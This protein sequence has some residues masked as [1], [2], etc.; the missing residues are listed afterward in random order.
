MNIQEIYDYAKLATLSYVDLSRY[1]R[2]TLDATDVIKE[3]ASAN[4]PGKQERI[5]TALGDQMFN[6]LKPADITGK[7]TILDP[8]FKAD[9]STGHSDPAS[10]FAAMLVKND[11]TGN[12][13]LAI[14]GTEPGAPG[15]AIQD[16]VESDGGGRSD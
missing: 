7:W 3:S 9:P 16:L 15:Q 8:Y 11:T 1:T 13:V 6:L 5:S 14:A 12:K 4:N 10:G 2:S